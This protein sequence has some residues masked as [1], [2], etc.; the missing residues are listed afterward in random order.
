MVSSR[1]RTAGKVV[2]ASSHD[3][4]EFASKLVIG[5]TQKL[6]IPTAFGVG[7]RHGWMDNRRMYW[8]RLLGIY[9]R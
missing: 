5:V 6:H 1:K 9:P 3:T 8:V 4:E 7:L 2:W